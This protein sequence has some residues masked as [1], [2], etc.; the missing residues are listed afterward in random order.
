MTKRKRMEYSSYI[1][2]N[3][4]I[5]F[6]CVTKIRIFKNVNIRRKADHNICSNLLEKHFRQLKLYS[7]SQSW[8]VRSCYHIGIF[9]EKNVAVHIF[10]RVPFPGLTT[11]A[12]ITRENVCTRKQVLVRNLRLYLATKSKN[13]VIYYEERLM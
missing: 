7:N 8:L 1:F 2:A 4:N 13:W 6:S 3:V 5:H 9:L 12:L 11:R 10:A